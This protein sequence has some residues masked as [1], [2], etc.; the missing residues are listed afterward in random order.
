MQTNNLRL[1]V[2]RTE[3]DIARDYIAGF[4]VIGCGLKKPDHYCALAANLDTL[5]LDIVWKLFKLGVEDGLP[6]E[7]DA[8]NYLFSKTSKLMA[9]YSMKKIF[10]FFKN[11]GLDCS[12]SFRGYPDQ[13]IIVERVRS[14][15]FVAGEEIRICESNERMKLRLMETIFRD[16]HLPTIGHTM[17]SELAEVEEDAAKLKAEEKENEGKRSALPSS[18]KKRNFAE[19]S[20]YVGKLFAQADQ[21]CDTATKKRELKWRTLALLAEFLKI[22]IMLR[23]KEWVSI[24]QFCIAQ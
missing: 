16:E 8:L 9:R 10:R 7:A 2:S 24:L 4:R 23:S 12:P 15:C 18:T 13:T 21:V 22:Q 1:K 14:T 19:I 20:P 3:F 5:N 17:R 6:Q 11:I